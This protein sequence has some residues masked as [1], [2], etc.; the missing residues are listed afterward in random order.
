MIKDSS[1]KPLYNRELQQKIVT[2][3]VLL[4]NGGI[5]AVTGGI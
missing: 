4:L 3:W 5:W 2:Q 1:A